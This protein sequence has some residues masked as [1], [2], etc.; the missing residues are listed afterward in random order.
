MADV[1]MDSRETAK[2]SKAGKPESTTFAAVILAAGYSSRMKRFKPLLPVEGTTALER[3]AASVRSAGIEEL[4]VVTGYRRELLEPVM[5]KT[6]AVEAY[7]E[8]YDT[9]MFSSIKTGIRRA[10]ELWSGAKGFFLMPVDCPLIDSSVI[11]KMIGVITAGGETFC[12]PVFEGK[13]GHPLYIPVR[14]ADEICRY[15]GR[16]GL[17]AVTDRHWEKMARVPVEDEGCLLDMDTPEGYREIQDF[18]KAGRRRRDV[19]SLARGR[20]IFL[21]RHGQTQQHREKMFIGQYDVSLSGEGRAQAERAGQE[22]ARLRPETEVI[23]TSDLARAVESAEI[24]GRQLR[25][26][27]RTEMRLAPR[28]GLREISLGSWDGRPVREI[29]EKY[30]EQ[31]RKRGEDIFTFKTGNGAENFY[32]M[33]YRA[34]KAL[35]EILEEDE[36]RDVVIVAHSG[37]IRALENNLRGARVDDRWEPIPKGSFRVVE[38]C[39]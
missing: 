24:L 21:V 26:S 30:P 19:A 35:R 17:K 38:L 33:Q 39:P 6:G 7:N 37:V 28:R 27:R 4:V 13:K 31:Y 34:V 1:Q 5:E 16:G 23:Y 11:R 22:M 15:E 36:R 8:N 18:L 25:M 14:Y 9:G 20:R 29:R 32:D 12:V 10:A 2:I 3:L